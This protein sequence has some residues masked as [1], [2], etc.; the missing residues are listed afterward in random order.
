MLIPIG[1]VFNGDSDFEIR[2]ADILC[3]ACQNKQKQIYKS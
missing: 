2:L 3:K 1:T